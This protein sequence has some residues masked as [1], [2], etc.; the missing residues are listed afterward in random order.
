MAGVAAVAVFEFPN[1][2]FPLFAKG[3]DDGAA[4]AVVLC[5]CEALL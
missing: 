5:D 1:K 4:V 3:P 2:D